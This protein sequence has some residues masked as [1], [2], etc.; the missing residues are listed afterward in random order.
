MMQ[1]IQ[2]YRSGKLS[3]DEVPA[4]VSRA[5]GL[6]VATQNSLISAGTERASAQV[7]RKNLLGKAIERPDLVRK[8]WSQVE[9]NGLVKT[10]QLVFSRLDAPVAQDSAFFHI[11][12]GQPP[13]SS[14]CEGARD[15]DCSVP[16]SVGLHHRHHFH[17]GPHDIAD[18]AKI[19]GDLFQRDFNPGSIGE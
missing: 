12:H 16:V 13:G 6:I 2:N 15:F 14:G 3:L 19:F 10:A 1:L 8:V 4:P 7:A 5:D 11:A 17:V 9:K 18:R